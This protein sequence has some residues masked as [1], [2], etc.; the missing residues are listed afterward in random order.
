[1]FSLLVP[2]LVAFLFLPGWEIFTFD[3]IVVL[4]LSFRVLPDGVKE[5]VFRKERPALF[6]RVD[7]GRVLE[8]FYPVDSQLN[9]QHQDECINRNNTVSAGCLCLFYLIDPSLFFTGDL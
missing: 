8:S 7:S 1:M 9:R 2:F 5:T 4:L 6:S 3:A